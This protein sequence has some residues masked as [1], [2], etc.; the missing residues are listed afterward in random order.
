MPTGTQHFTVGNERFSVRVVVYRTVRAMRRE[1]YRRSLRHSGDRLRLRGARGCCFETNDKR[2]PQ[3]A[4]LILLAQPYLGV[5]TISH[6]CF[7]ATMRIMARRGFGTLHLNGAG[8]RWALKRSQIEE[9]AAH[10]QGE[11]CKVIVQVLYARKL[12][13]PELA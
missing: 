7:H 5:G 6:E 9:L 11:L 12:I 4:A 1:I 10:T 13:R 2:C 3:I 8:R